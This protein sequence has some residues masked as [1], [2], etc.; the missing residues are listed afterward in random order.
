MTL[1]AEEFIR[2][3]L[4]HV[5][6]DRF[7]RIRHFGFLANRYRAEKIERARQ[8]LTPLEEAAVN[9]PTPDEESAD[10]KT[11]LDDLWLCPECRKGRLIRIETLAPATGMLSEVEGIDSS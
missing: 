2:R 1:R 6:P 8:L 9:V 5:L 11:D 7:V 10:P 3:F 4:L